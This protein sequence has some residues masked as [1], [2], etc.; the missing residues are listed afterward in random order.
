[1]IP[2]RKPIS[3]RKEEARQL[4]RC[5]ECGEAILRRR[6][7]ARFCSG[8]CK[9]RD[10]RRQIKVEQ[11]VEEIQTQQKSVT[12]LPA[13]AGKRVTKRPPTMPSRNP[14]PG[15]IATLGDASCD[16]PD[17]DCDRGVTP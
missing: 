1:M 5:W 17:G 3:L 9:Q 11:A 15:R 8:K 4:R 6:K 10:Y 13:I 2:P 16:H 14:E 12:L 7:N